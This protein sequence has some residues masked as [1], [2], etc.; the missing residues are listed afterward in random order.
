MSPV[1]AHTAWPWGAGAA[2]PSKCQWGF[3]EDKLETIWESKSI[4]TQCGVSLIASLSAF[5]CNELSGSAQR[6]AETLG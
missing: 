2:F 4:P 6:G 5:N 1:P 3:L